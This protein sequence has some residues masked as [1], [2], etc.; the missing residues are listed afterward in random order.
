MC[1]RCY[2]H[3]AIFDGYL[4]GTLIETLEARVLHHQ[5]GNIEADE[6]R[7]GRGGGLSALASQGRTRHRP[8]CPDAWE[9]SL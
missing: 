6:R 9:P 7:G 4:D 5:F 2:I 1:R 8:E 3:P